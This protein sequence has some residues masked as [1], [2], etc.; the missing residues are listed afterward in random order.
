[1]WPQTLSQELLQPEAWRKR[2]ERTP[3]KFLPNEG[4]AMLWPWNKAGIFI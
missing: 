3:C 2:Q 1:M 4:P